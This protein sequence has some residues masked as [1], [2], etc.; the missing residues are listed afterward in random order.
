MIVLVGIAITWILRSLLNQL[1]VEDNIAILIWLSGVLDRKPF[2]CDFCL[3]FWV[4]LGFFL[5]T[6]QYPAFLIPIGYFI[7]IE[8]F[9]RIFG[10]AY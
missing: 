2:N 6:N 1:K 9:K 8:T 3:S 10:K 5:T 4:G 7:T